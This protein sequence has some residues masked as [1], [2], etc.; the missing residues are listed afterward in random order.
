MKLLTGNSNKILSK[1]IAKY[2]VEALP[3]STDFRWH[4]L[5]SQTIEEA[6][7]HIRDYF[8]EPANEDC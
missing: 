3:D 1:N 4:L 7:T 8:S 2:F 5:R 6:A